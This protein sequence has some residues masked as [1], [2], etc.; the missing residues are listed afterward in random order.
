MRQNEVELSAGV[1]LTLRVGYKL[2]DD[3]IDA[4]RFAAAALHHVQVITH[5]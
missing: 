1:T 4:R 5:A 3:V 2:L